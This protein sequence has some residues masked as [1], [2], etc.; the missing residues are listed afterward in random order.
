[1]ATP[2]RS[3]CS[4]KRINPV[5]RLDFTEIFTALRIAKILTEMRFLMMLR[6]MSSTRNA[7]R[8]KPNE[9][10]KRGGW[11][12]VTGCLAAVGAIFFL[13]TACS[14]NPDQSEGAGQNGTSAPPAAAGT[15]PAAP[16]ES[17]AINAVASTG[18][19]PATNIQPSGQ[20]QG[21]P[22]EYVTVTNGQGEA[23]QASLLIQVDSQ[24]KLDDGKFLTTCP[25][26][27]DAKYPVQML[28]IITLG[29]SIEKAQLTLKSGGRAVNVGG[30]MADSSGQ[31][32]GFGVGIQKAPG[33]DYVLQIVSTNAE[34]F[35]FKWQIK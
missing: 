34:K 1:M 15:N 9:C 30:P 27:F 14:K 26:K 4:S 33:G 6:R 8:I 20:E 11:I 21:N 31:R 5:L 3:R 13:G 12:A 19:P 28:V 22:T 18:A 17:A 25:V 24:N 16:Q 35:Q 23:Y 10:V 7:D 29:N 32:V 2:R